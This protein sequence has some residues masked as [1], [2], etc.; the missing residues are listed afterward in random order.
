M[1]KEQ[2]DY[3]NW[4]KEPKFKAISPENN[5]T[6]EE[7]ID[8]ITQ[9]KL[10]R[11]SY[12]N[13]IV[14][15][16]EKRSLMKTYTE[17]WALSDLDY[18]LD[19]PDT[20]DIQG[21]Y[22][23]DWR[24]ERCLM[25]IINDLI[26]DYEKIISKYDPF[27]LKDPKKTNKDL[28]EIWLSLC[29][30]VLRWSREEFEEEIWKK[31]EKIIQQ[32]LKD[33]IYLQN[34]FYYE[35]AFHAMT[36]PDM[37]LFETIMQKWNAIKHPLF[38]KVK[39]ASVFYLMGEKNKAQIMWMEAL[40][41]LRPH[42]PKSKIKDDFNLLSI[43]G[44]ILANLFLTTTHVSEQALNE[45]ISEQ[46][47]NYKA[48]L[49]D[50]E[51]IGCSPLE[52]LRKFALALDGQKEGFFTKRSS[53]DF[54]WHHESVTFYHCWPPLY[55]HVFQYLRF[56]EEAGIPFLP[57]DTM[58]FSLSFISKYSPW[59][60]FC[61]L[62]IIGSG[63]WATCEIAFS[64]KK[65]YYL[66]S[67]KN[68]S[69]V[70]NY[71]RQLNHLITHK[72]SYLTNTFNNYYAR[73]AKNLFDVISRLTTKAKPD[74]L[75]RI[76]DLG[77]ELYKV[78]DDKF[79]FQRLGS[80]YFKRLFDAMSPQQI[81]SI[82]DQL[83]SIPIS[84]NQNGMWESPALFVDWRG[85]TVSPHDMTPQLKKTIQHLTEELDTDNAFYRSEVLHYLNLCIEINLLS[86][87][88]KKTIAK[89]L[90]NHL[91]PPDFPQI[92]NNYFFAYRRYL[93]PFNK[94]HEID[95][96][97]KNYY[98]RT[99]MTVFE[100]SDMNTLFWQDETPFVKMSKS[101][102]ATCS[103]FNK[104]EW[105]FFD[106]TTDECTLLF[107]N[108]KNNL[109]SI[110][111]IEKKCDSQVL[112]QDDANAM[113]KKTYQS[114]DMIFGTVIVPRLNDEKTLQDINEFVR[115]IEKIYC[116]PITAVAFMAKKGMYDFSYIVDTVSKFN[117]SDY[118]VF[119]SYA[120]SIYNA[121]RFSKQKDLPTPP[122]QLFYALVSAVNMKSDRT[123]CSACTIL[124]YIL[125]VYSPPETECSIILHA[126]KDLLRTTSF[127]DQNER[128]TIQDRYD[129]RQSAAYLAA[130]MYRLYQK[131]KREIPPELQAWYDLR[132]SKD[133]L[134]DIRNTWM[135][136]LNNA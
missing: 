28:Q 55:V 57:G 54:D 44:S 89:V 5:K 132:E 8:Q 25:P 111:S 20:W 67:E 129:Y 69:L 34:R 124:G 14:L 96:V 45:E 38:W 46:K 83:L 40:V 101:L 10:E 62:N 81:F 2:P 35:Q 125:S 79:F 24:L 116:F 123:F 90:W 77:I 59:W 11:E 15:P 91:T 36:L 109:N 7:R 104:N 100:K 84:L 113:I 121:Y 39:I 41:E 106:L 117:E 115:D 114:I 21:L 76:F 93:D 103:V 78:N 47:Q 87:S 120:Y 108:I 60:A 65:I 105:M 95:N 82:L 13:W 52:E 99:S 128:F 19:L 85:F 119:Y 27:G 92:A 86:A 50:L 88:C 49:Q 73:L 56:F 16:W 75:Q 58:H 9:W 30:S 29:F 133:E 6:K 110:V 31:Y 61:L 33:D 26:E 32:V 74:N 107:N 17:H 98:F 68:N 118:M 130:C 70:E 37:N 131:E 22:E 94:N 112:F 126:L 23:L 48:R 97:I 135:D 134:P 122:M 43:E 1:I 12:P 4:P 18:L 63:Q 72:R 80:R 53:R 127:S 102:L 3:Y 136:V 71:I 51:Q 66:S 64:Q 42:I